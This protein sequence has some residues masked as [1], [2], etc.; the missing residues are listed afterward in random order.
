MK[1]LPGWYGVK[2]CHGGQGKFHRQE[3]GN[4]HN[5]HHGGAVGIPL[6]PVTRLLAVESKDWQSS[7]KWSKYLTF[8]SKII[9]SGRSSGELCQ[10]L[11]FSV[12]VQSPTVRSGKLLTFRWSPV[13]PCCWHLQSCFFSHYCWSCLSSTFA[14][15]ARL[16][17]WQRTEGCWE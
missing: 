13:W 4:D 10:D 5:Q 8:S 14:A 7:A 2:R 17:A 12:I 1:A 3:H 6:P 9:S 15:S 16:F 11:S